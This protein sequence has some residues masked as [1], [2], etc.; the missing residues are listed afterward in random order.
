MRFSVIIVN[1]NGGDYLAGALASLAR[2][3]VSD[4]EVFVVDN[5]S[6]DGSM[7]Q[8]GDE[9]PDALHLFPQEENLGFAAANNLAARAAKGDWIV[10]LNPDAAAEPNWLEKLAWMARAMLIS[11]SAFPGAAA[12]VARFLR[13]RVKG[14]ALPH[15]ARARC[16]TERCS[17]R[18]AGSMKSC[19]AFAKMSTLATGYALLA[20]NVFSCQKQS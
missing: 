13:C 2:Q 6:S 7:N 11:V 4:F 10:L 17:S 18:M 16:I 1:Y 5:A 15:A 3:T 8:L 14:R 9:L 20:S 19:F 12:L